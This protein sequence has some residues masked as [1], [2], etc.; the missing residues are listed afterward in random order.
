MDSGEPTSVPLP[1]RARAVDEGAFAPEVSVVNVAGAEEMIATDSVV[2]DLVGPRSPEEVT[3]TDLAG[4]VGGESWPEETNS[5]MARAVAP[6]AI[7]PMD[8][9]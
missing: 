4:A 2:A 7:R 9:I 1:V 8:M 6:R 5:G 3:S